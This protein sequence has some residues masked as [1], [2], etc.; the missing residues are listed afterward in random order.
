MKAVILASFNNFFCVDLIERLQRKEIPPV[1]LAVVFF[2]TSFDSKSYEIHH[3]RTLGHYRRKSIC[4]VCTPGTPCYFSDDVNSSRTVKL[5]RDLRADVC[6]QG[7]VNKIL[8]GEILSVCPLG[9]VNVHPGWLPHF[10]GCTCVEWA[11][12]LDQP[13]CNTAHFCDEGIDTGPIIHIE[14]P[15]LD[16]IRSYYELRSRVYQHRLEMMVQALWKIRDGVTPSSA[17][18]Q[19]SGT[20]H[21]IM[22]EPLLSETIRKFETGNYRPPTYA[23]EDFSKV[24]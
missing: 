1:D 14:R 11:I 10:R 18:S 19:G 6:I 5:V 16:G 20:Y 23:A 2:G 4:E 3:E 22:R 8:K 17:S 9:V 12:H 15:P 21:K 13:I 7:E 24:P